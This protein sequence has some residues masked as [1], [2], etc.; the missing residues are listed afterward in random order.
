MYI[1]LLVG[2]LYSL[3]RDD[4]SQQLQQ[5]FT[6]QCSVMRSTFLLTLSPYLADLFPWL[7]ACNQVIFCLISQF[8]F[9]SW[10]KTPKIPKKKRRLIQFLNPQEIVLFLINHNYAFTLLGM[11]LHSQCLKK[12]SKQSD[13]LRFIFKEI[14]SNAIMQDEKNFYH[15]RKSE[16]EKNTVHFP[17]CMS[18]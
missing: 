15:Y 16:F 8:S 14:S 5:T 13:S 9:F 17:T 1:N 18:I 10:K 3:N 4:N 2:A 6:E 7:Y 12:I 11:E